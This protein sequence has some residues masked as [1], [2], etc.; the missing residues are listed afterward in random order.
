[1][2]SGWGTGSQWWEGWT[3]EHLSWAWRWKVTDDKSGDNYTEPTCVKWD[4]REAEEQQTDN[5][6]LE[7]EDNWFIVLPAVL[8]K[9]TVVWS[10]II[11]NLTEH[12]SIRRRNSNNSMNC[13]SQHEQVEFKAATQQWQ[14]V[15]QSVA[16]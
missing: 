14:Q 8:E 6:E 2:S 3:G 1:M 16:F 10:L 12:L 7:C 15:V 5:N 4:E 13:S 9:M 11:S